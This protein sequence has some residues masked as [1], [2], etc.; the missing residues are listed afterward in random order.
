M[1]RK[2]RETLLLLVILCILVAIPEVSIAE[3][4]ARTIVV[5]DDYSSIQEA[6]YN[7]DEGDSIFVRSGTYIGTLDINKSVAI[8]GENKSDTI[9][10][11]DSFT[12]HVI[13]IL[14]HTRNVTIT[15]F[16]I[17]NSNNDP[18]NNVR[19]GVYIRYSRG[20]HNI[21]NNIITHN[22]GEGIYFFR[23][24]TMYSLSPS[25][26]S[27]NNIDNCWGYGILVNE[28]SFSN[29]IVGNILTNNT[30][31]IDI[32]RSSNQTVSSNVIQ[33]ST[34][35]GIL[36]GHSYNTSICDNIITDV[37]DYGIAVSSS[38]DNVIYKNVVSNTPK[39]IHIGS[40]GNS[41]IC[42]NNITENESGISIFH[43]SNNT[44]LGNIISNN[45]VGINFTESETTNT[46]I[47]KN[48]FINNTKQVSHFAND[49]IAI[50]DNGVEG[51]YW[52]DYTG[53][54]SDGNGIGDTAYVINE[55][56]HDNYPLVEPVDMETIPE[57]P[58][59]II[60]PILLVAILS[61]KIIKATKSR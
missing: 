4:E 49:T 56:N 50:W 22:A 21:S 8:I 15:G 10:D 40:L 36:T 14:P 18:G 47:Y 9:I 17:Q 23:S 31:G 37:S 42:L 38:S 54:D 28:V 44:I 1:M 33:G 25:L 24:S 3:A 61:A 51:N 41:T 58:S 55:N 6:I 45:N 19:H 48:D 11:G 26:V 52:S 27:G 5:P 2:R 16:T 13:D 60:L 29:K 46:T 30:G 34:I 39:G 35:G 20:G 12:D 53:T 32:H 59:W 7:A 57:S 43:S